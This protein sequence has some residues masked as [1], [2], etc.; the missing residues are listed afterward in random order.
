MPGSARSWSTEASQ[1][2]PSWP[3]PLHLSRPSET[4]SAIHCST[5]YREPLTSAI[6]K[7]SDPSNSQRRS[8]SSSPLHS[9]QYDP[10]H[11]T[12]YPRYYI[13]SLSP[14]DTPRSAPIS[15][16]ETWRNF[17]ISTLNLASSTDV[18]RVVLLS[19]QALPATTR[20]RTGI[21]FVLLPEAST[22]SSCT[23]CSAIR[24]FPTFPRLLF[25]G[26]A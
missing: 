15:H 16:I 3:R 25:I 13:P 19:N 10:I 11:S 12:R 2:K 23:A 22:S 1:S 4:I 9:S 5:P 18:Q 26:G 14:H 24:V 20:Q 21:R 6:N 8:L 17:P 7:L